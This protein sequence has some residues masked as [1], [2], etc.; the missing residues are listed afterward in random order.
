MS[1]TVAC[2]CDD[3]LCTRLA[4]ADEGVPSGEEMCEECQMGNHDD[5]PSDDDD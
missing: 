2:T 4:F 3:C 1:R 5:D